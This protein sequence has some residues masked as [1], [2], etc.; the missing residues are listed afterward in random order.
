MVCQKARSEPAAHTTHLGL[1]S[2]A[3][4]GV[5]L[6][7]TSPSCS[8]PLHTSVFKTSRWGDKSRASSWPASTRGCKPTALISSTSWLQ[9]THSPI[10][11]PPPVSPHKARCTLSKHLLPMHEHFL[12]QSSWLGD[13]FMSR[14][15]AK[16]GWGS[17]LRDAG[18]VFGARGT[19]W[20]P[21]DVLFLQG[22][23]GSQPALRFGSSG[24]EGI[25]PSY[26]QK[27]PLDKVR[28]HP[29]SGK[30]VFPRRPCQIVRWK[31]AVWQS[32]ARCQT[33]LVG[34]APRCSSSLLF[35]YCEQRF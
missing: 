5:T 20:P 35:N 2:L 16:H 28:E 8:L 15:W 13:V 12:L 11:H 30:F 7:P 31:R 4:P 21:R 34:Q 10:N 6:S 29:G 1:P 25:P 3:L 17:A 14:T 9:T 24:T 23:G 18:E 33:D 22:R 19:H 26:L 32:R 27:S